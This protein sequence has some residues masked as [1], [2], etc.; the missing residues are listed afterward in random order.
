MK[1]LPCGLKRIHKPFGQIIGETLYFENEGEIK[2][3]HLAFMPFIK[4]K[5]ERL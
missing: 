1:P 3:L 5:E 2:K 4:N